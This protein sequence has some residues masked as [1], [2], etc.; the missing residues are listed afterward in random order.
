M[1]VSRTIAV[2]LGL[3][4]MVVV[5]WRHSTAP[6]ASTDAPPPAARAAAPAPTAAAS[7][8]APAGPSQIDVAAMP[9]AP[10]PETGAP[11]VAREDPLTAYR[12]ANIYPP[13]SRPLSS[14]H[15]DLLRPNQRHE[16]MQAADHGD[17][18]RFLF[19]ADRYF[20]IGDEILTSTL[21]VERNGEPLSVTL[22]R[23]F[24]VV[25]DP[26]GH[27]ERPIPL[28]FTPSGTGFAHSFTPARLGLARQAAIAMYVEF[29]DGFATQR[30]H[31]DFQYTPTAGIP[32]RFTGRF[33]AAVEAG[34]LAI[35]VGVE[36]TT[37]GSYL[38]D[39]NLFDARDQPVAWARFKGELAA[40]THDAAL[41]F[42]GKAI[43]DADAAGPFHLGQLRGARYAPGSDPDLE[44]MPPFAGSFT[45]QPYPADAFSDAEYDSPDKQRMIELLGAD[46]GHRGAATPTQPTQ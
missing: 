40:G 6:V 15:A 21:A 34:S 14:E 12:K 45:T 32:A 7:P 5:W 33:R 20:V 41:V 23:A 19:T 42:F 38:I 36:V 17:G 9:L 18:V 2:A 31:F 13:T 3:V 39:A 43:R 46:Q 27:D 4:M 24:A 37:P 29:D 30:G 8:H 44:Q 11:G 10:Y 22:K 16:S 35:R 28:M 25:V 26:I 1:S